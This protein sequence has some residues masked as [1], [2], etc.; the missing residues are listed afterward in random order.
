MQLQTNAA[1]VANALHGTSAQ[2]RDRNMR[3]EPEAADAPE[4]VD[5]ALGVAGGDV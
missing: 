3:Y 4:P 5:S 2:T 1:A